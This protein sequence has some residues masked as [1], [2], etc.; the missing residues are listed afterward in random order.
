M[1][2]SAGS[3]GAQADS[4]RAVSPEKAAAIRTLLE[5]TNTAE[6]FL[7]G[8]EEAAAAQ[9]T[10]AELP[11]DFWDRFK[12]KVR[13]QVPQFLEMLIPVY[14][15]QLSLEDVNGLIEF[16]RTPL[17]RRYVAAQP[18]LTSE[19]MRVGQRWAMMVVGQVFM[20]MSNKPPSR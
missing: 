5:V 2:L 14:D 8:F 7:H 15:A 4:A 1:A 20:E 9:P 11:E 17:G 16:Y 3:L 10:S 13:T 18:P 12:A 6:M 19:M